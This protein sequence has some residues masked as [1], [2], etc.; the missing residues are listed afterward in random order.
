MQQW[1]CPLWNKLCKLAFENGAGAIC[2]P[3][4]LDTKHGHEYCNWLK[5]TQ[6]LGLFTKIKQNIQ[7]IRLDL[8]LDAHL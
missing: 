1:Q 5:L 3:T 8:N 2:M 4:V 6:Q 7:N